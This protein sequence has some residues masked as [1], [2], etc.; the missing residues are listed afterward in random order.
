MLV[1]SRLHCSGARSPKMSNQNIQ[2]AWRNVDGSI[3]GTVSKYYI[4]LTFKTSIHIADS[5]IRSQSLVSIFLKLLTDW[6]TG[7]ATNWQYFAYYL[8]PNSTVSIFHLLNVGHPISNC[9]LI[10]IPCFS[11][12]TEV[13]TDYILERSNT[14]LQYDCYPSGKVFKMIP[15]ALFSVFHAKYRFET[16]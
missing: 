10:I 8:G 4:F 2:Y 12:K 5:A 6:K 15:C 7:N 16:Q 3:S 13:M 1:A 11:V 14:S 9:Y